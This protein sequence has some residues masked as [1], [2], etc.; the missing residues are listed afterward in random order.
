MGLGI[1]EFHDDPDLVE[2]TPGDRPEWV[3]GKACRFP[4]DSDGTAGGISIVDVP[5]GQPGHIFAAPLSNSV[6]YKKGDTVFAA[7]KN[8]CLSTGLEI[9][10]EIT[11]ENC[12]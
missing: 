8:N 9:T 6:Q 1:L 4:M 11:F 12:D 7:Y 3:P 10:L 5:A 2:I